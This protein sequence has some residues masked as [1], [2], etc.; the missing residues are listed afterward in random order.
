MPAKIKNDFINI[1]ISAKS[2]RILRAMA[3]SRG[4]DMAEMIDIA[5]E[6]YEPLVRP[7]Q[8]VN[9]HITTPPPD[10]DGA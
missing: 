8:Q 4:I 9:G 10:R 1:R 7:L 6:P 2:H 3:A 5:A